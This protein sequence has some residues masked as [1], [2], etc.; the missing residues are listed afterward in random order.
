V[1][2]DVHD[3][4]FKSAGQAQMRKAEVDGHATPFLFGE[5][6]WVDPG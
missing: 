4:D 2:W 1:A 5:P 6:V 3:S